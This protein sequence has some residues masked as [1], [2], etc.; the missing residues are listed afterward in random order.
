[1]IPDYII[2]Q[3]ESD[4]E[5]AIARTE[6]FMQTIKNA[7]FSEHIKGMMI[8]A[9]KCNIALLEENEKLRREIKHGPCVPIGELMKGGKNG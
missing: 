8:A 7:P 2:E 9:L 6:N 5:K 1:M 4:W 3:M